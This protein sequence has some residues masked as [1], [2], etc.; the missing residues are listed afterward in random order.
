MKTLAQR[1]YDSW[2][3][4]NGS[5]LS[6]AGGQPASARGPRRQAK[7]SAV[8]GAASFLGN[9]TAPLIM[10]GALPRGADDNAAAA[11]PARHDKQLPDLP[12]VIE[13]DPES[14]F[15]AAGE[16]YYLGGLR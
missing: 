12:R 9:A 5:R 4:Q 7:R 3:R 1:V 11:S 15:L 14:I 16:D 8:R 10:P 6:A 13:K 2:L